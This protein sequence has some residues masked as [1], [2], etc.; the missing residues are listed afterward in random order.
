[1]SIFHLNICSAQYKINELEALLHSLNQ[2]YRAVI[3]TEHWLT[4]V[5]SPYYCPNSYIVGAAF[6]RKSLQHGGVLIQ[7]KNSTKYENLPYLDNLAIELHCELAAVKLQPENIILVGMYRSPQV[8]EITCK[9]N[10]IIV[11][12]FNICFIKKGTPYRTLMSLL[13]SYGFYHSSESKTR[14]DSCLDNFLVNMEMR[15]LESTVIPHTIS[16]HQAIAL[17]VNLSSLGVQQSKKDYVCCQPV[18]KCGLQNFENGIRI[19]RWDFI[20]DCQLNLET[21]WEYFMEIFF[22]S[23]GGCIPLEE[24]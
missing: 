7:I 20:Y 24:S 4:N 5:A 6:C 10:T 16:D 11:G 2:N 1:M 23:Y 9:Y 21:K 22:I 17:N 18:T 8:L 13:T 15:H 3:L 19:E 14:K 12:D